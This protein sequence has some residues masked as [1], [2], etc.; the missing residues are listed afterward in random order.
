MGAEPPK[1]FIWP[2]INLSL[3]G[4]CVPVLTFASHARACFYRVMLSTHRDRV[5]DCSFFGPGRVLVKLGNSGRLD[6]L[7][8]SWR[9]SRR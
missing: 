7:E 8:Q 1:S 9:I 5:R 3:C 2:P 4:G 6:T